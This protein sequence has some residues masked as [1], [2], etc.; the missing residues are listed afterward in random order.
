MVRRAHELDPLVHRTD[1][2]SMLLRAGQF[3]AALDAA[4]QAVDFDPDDARAHAVLG[5][6]HLKLGE[7]AEGIALLEQAVAKAPENMMF[8][9]QLGEALALA[10]ETARARDILRAVGGSLSRTAR[11]AIPLRVRAH[12]PRRARSC[13]GLVG[14]GVR[15]PG[16]KHLRR[17]GVVSLHVTARASALRRAS[18]EDESRVTTS[19]RIEC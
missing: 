7:A 9:A 2:A 1:V 5:W 19:R 14:T 4:K 8:L 10:G 3:D 17:E 15:G 13:N 6:A 11:V 16:W 18:D 12:R